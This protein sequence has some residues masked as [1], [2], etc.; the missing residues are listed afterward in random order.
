M[1]T[2]LPI[3]AQISALMIEVGAKLDASVALVQDA[4][5]EDE[6]IRYRSVV[7]QLMGTM[8]LDV[9]APLYR[10]HPAL[11]PDWLE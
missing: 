4:C 2:N 9:M 3:A 11:K 7:G 5:P 10:Q 8:F 1:I 6:L